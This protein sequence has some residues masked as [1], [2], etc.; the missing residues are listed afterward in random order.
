[1]IIYKLFQ[2]ILSRSWNIPL[3]TND[4][5]KIPHLPI[6]PI[7]HHHPRIALLQYPIH[8]IHLTPRRCLAPHLGD[9]L[10]AS[11]V[12]H[13]NAPSVVML[14]WTEEETKRRKRVKTRN[15]PLKR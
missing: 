13:M 4:I 15:Q 1:T 8:R 14:P 2:I 11:V 12:W 3:K 10:T 9:I 7:H 6:P 5:V